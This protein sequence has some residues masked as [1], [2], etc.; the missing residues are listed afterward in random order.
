MGQNASK[1]AENV[2]FIGFRLVQ[3]LVSVA[4]AVVTGGVTAPLAALSLVSTTS[5]IRDFINNPS[6]DP[7]RTI[8]EAIDTI[9]NAIGFPT[10][11]HHVVSII[12]KAGSENFAGAPLGDIVPSGNLKNEQKVAQ[13]TITQVGRATGAN[14]TVAPSSIIALTNPYIR[15]LRS[16][17][18]NSHT[19]LMLNTINTGI[20]A[21]V[22]A[23]AS[24]NRGTSIRQI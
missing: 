15:A 2:A 21:Q 8:K 22:I 13:N 3:T 24:P 6:G 23:G 16:S 4:G 20:N 7:N 18:N 1:I 10:A 19:N 5:S 11:T 9:G 14:Q 17:N 12:N